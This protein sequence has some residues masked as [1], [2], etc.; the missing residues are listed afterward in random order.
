MFQVSKVTVNPI[1]PLTGASRNRG[2]KE[3]I[4]SPRTWKSLTCQLFRA[5][6]IF[7]GTTWYSRDA[8]KF[9]KDVS[10]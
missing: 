5:D 9:S 2:E 4:G 7:G 3:F 6:G 10:Q 1:R 8:H